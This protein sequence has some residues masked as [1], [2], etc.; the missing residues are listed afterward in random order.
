MP[1]AKYLPDQ[2]KVL[3]W[4][5]GTL[6][7][8]GD[9]NQVLLLDTIL[10]TPIV[11]TDDIVRIELILSEAVLFLQSIQSL[12]QQGLENTSDVI[13]ELKLRIS[14]A[15]KVTKKGVKAQ[16][17]ET[18]CLE[19]P[20]SSLKMV[21]SG[22]VLQLKRL[23]RHIPALAIASAINERLTDL[24]VGGR[25][26]IENA[27]RFH[28]FSEAARRQTF[29]QWPHMD[30]KWALPDQMA[31]AGFY[32]QPGDSGVDRAM[33]FTCNVCLVCWEKTDE[34]WSEHERHSPDCPFVKGEYTQNVPLAV[35]YATSPAVSITRFTV[36]SNDMQSNIVCTGNRDGEVNVWNVERPL[37]SVTK[38]NVTNVDKSLQNVLSI[39]G[40][41]DIRLTALATYMKTGKTMSGINSGATKKVGVNSSRSKMVGTK[42][43]AGVSVSQRHMSSSSSSG[44][45]NMDHDGEHGNQL[46][47]IVYQLN[48]TVGKAQKDHNNTLGAKKS[49]STLSTIEERF[50]DDEFMKFLASET[51]LQQLQLLE[52]Y[53]DIEKNLFS[54]ESSKNDDQKLVKFKG[55][56]AAWSQTDSIASTLSADCEKS[57]I[58]ASTNSLSAVVTVA[59][60]QIFPVTTLS[61]SIDYEI[62]QI[63]PTPDLSHLLVVVKPVATNTDTIS[64]E[65][66]EEASLHSVQLV[67]FR[68]TDGGLVEETPITSQVLAENEAPLEICMLPTSDAKRRLSE[69][70]D[71]E[72]EGGFF[73]MTCTDGSL[74]LFSLTTLKVVSEARV[75]TGKFISVTYCKSLERICGAT[76]KGS[77]HFYSFFEFDADS[78]DE[79]DEDCAD[80]LPPSDRTNII[81]DAMPSTS[82]AI[83]KTSHATN[84]DIDLIAY[85]QN[86][87]LNDLRVLYS[88]TMFDEMPLPYNAE[89][90]GCWSELIQA[91]KQRRHPNHL[92]QG[93]ETNSTRTWRLHNDATTW[94]EHLIEINLPKNVTQSIGHI[95]FKFTLYQ[96]CTN[97]PAIQLTLLKQK[98]FGLCCRRKTVGEDE[99]SGATG[100]S[101]SDYRDSY[102]NPV[103]SEEFLQARNA[104][105]L[106]GPIE[107]ASYMDLSEQGGIVTLTSPKLLKSKSRNFLLHIKTVAD[108]SKDGQGKT[109]GK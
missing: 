85:R 2:D 28:M 17:W 103:L 74:K 1:R 79:R 80:T 109:R 76:D 39:P 47:L 58:N 3:F 106:A 77:L 107:L 56:A 37:Q 71:S 68:I 89:V 41:T 36:M 35:T 40:P 57:L 5:N 16:R 61:P 97:P 29:E 43:I 33:C 100:G 93:D 21:A 67:L 8:R 82:A 87:T 59:A 102:E 22:V 51:D 49:A 23:G 72:F 90:P 6:G 34:P 32:H 20:H 62:N 96:P 101:S 64:M 11:Q 18:I 83:P 53:I 38:F 94:D 46:A 31:Q 24:I 15:Q 81:Y 10:Q 7:L 91:Q 12:E 95:D 48:E 66:D 30:Y 65:I 60:V 50:E 13:N 70:T 86:L 84:R 54:D 52:N 45:E 69:V 42:I 14:E 44:A 27:N 92:R 104:E 25:V 75:D 88:L 55:S 4:N 78:S 63:L 26:D 105:I 98:S 99:S 19:L 108:S 73:A 9:Y